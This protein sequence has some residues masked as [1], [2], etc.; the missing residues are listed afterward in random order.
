[1]RCKA[2][3]W[4]IR[5]EGIDGAGGDCYNGQ[6]GLIRGERINPS[7]QQNDRTPKRQKTTSTDVDNTVLTPSSRFTVTPTTALHNVVNYPHKNEYFS[8]CKV[9]YSDPPGSFQ[10]VEFPQ[11]RQSITPNDAIELVSADTEND[12]DAFQWKSYDLARGNTITDAFKILTQ[13]RLTFEKVPEELPIVA[14]MKI[15]L[16]VYRTFDIEAADTGSPM[17]PDELMGKY[18]FSQSLSIRRMRMEN[19]SY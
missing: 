19:T 5:Y 16:A 2:F 12:T 13:K 10:N 8:K 14:G 4:E 9:F 1:M 3:C 15:G 18:G 6:L 7:P 17:E 11:F